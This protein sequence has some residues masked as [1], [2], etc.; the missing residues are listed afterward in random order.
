[1]SQGIGPGFFDEQEEGV[2]KDGDKK[3]VREVAQREPV[4]GGQDISEHSRGPFSSGRWPPPLTARMASAT[5]AALDGPDVVDAEDMGAPDQPDD[6]AA[7]VPSRRSSGGALR[8]LPM[9]DLRETPRRTGRPRSARRR[10][11]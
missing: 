6:R 9:N 1:M 4:E 8:I 5:R 11:R 3:D 2:E 10:G 7:I